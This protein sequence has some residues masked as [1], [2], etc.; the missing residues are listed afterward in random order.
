M[1]LSSNRIN[2]AELDFDDIKS[3]LVEFLRGQD[4]FKDY[5]FTG[6]GLS[7][8]MDLLA[9]NT[10]YNNLYTNLAVNEMFLDSAAKRDSVVSLAKM[11]G[12]TPRSATC[13]YSTVDVQI[14]N[15][16][17]NPAVTVLPAGQP[18]E[19]TVNGIQ[20]TFYNTGDY[21]CAPGPLGYVFS[22]VKII[23][24]T[25]LTYTYTT[26][27][28][29]RYII[30]NANVDVS[31]IKVTVQETASSGTFT[32]F[33]YVN[34]VYGAVDSTSP[35]FFVKE[36]DGGLLEIVFG[37]GNLGMALINGNVVTINYYVSSLD[38]PNGARLFNY[39]GIPLLGGSTNVSTKVIAAGG[40]APEDIESI[41][42]NAPRSFAAQGRAVTTQDYQTIIISN[43][44]EAKSVA[45]WGGESNSPAIYGKVFI[46]VLPTDAD[47]LTTT[48]KTQITGTLLANKNVV[49]V[50]P[51]IVDPDYINI[52]LDIT[53]YYDQSKTSK[54]IS[55]LQQILL[56]TVTTYNTQNLLNFNG[57][58]R[59]SELS[60]LL[61]TSDTSFVNNITTVILNRQIVP[62]YNVSA[63]YTINMINPIYT[64]NQPEG[65]IYSNGF[66]IYGD[67]VNTYYLDD[68]GLGNIR[69]YTLDSNY[70]K[71]IVN[72]TIGT[73]DYTTGLIVISNLKITS[74]VNQYFILSVKPASNDVVSALQQVAQIDFTNL[75]INVIPDLTAT[76]DLAAGYNYVFTPSRP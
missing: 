24:G 61:D 39:S 2:V 26:T 5:D 19:T 35:I 28:G 75:N 60:R 43:F 18:F 52:Q 17:S 22:S 59:F 68:D 21:T 67:S 65:N 73:V 11:L 56:D 31:T 15:P 53:S 44:P 1:P 38:A 48:Q 63:Q 41:R 49:S 10:H 32:N 62:Q 74:I 12:Y 57:V 3:N 13:S 45:V 42:F 7:I 71:N 76:G 34:N 69:L 23:E 47:K 8:L 70:Q 51:V 6:S 30:P 29:I 9:Y 66:S 16:T 55:Q 64:S 50:T 72:P 20:Y 14:I 54:S 33:Q 37:D 36:T 46:C 25:P 4:Q 40:S 58:F 27:P